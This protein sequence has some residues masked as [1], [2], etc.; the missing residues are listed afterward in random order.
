MNIPLDKQEAFFNWQIKEHQDEFSRYLNSSMKVLFERKEAFI[1]RVW[2]LDAARGNI[3]LRFK[4]GNC[5]RLKYPLQIITYSSTLDNTNPYDW[6]FS[7]TQF[8]ESYSINVSDISPI[9]YLKSTVDDGW[10]YIGCNGLTLDFIDKIS[11]SLSEGIKL[12]VVLAEQDPPIK[13]LLN[14]CNFVSNAKDNKTLN[15]MI[16]NEIENWRPRKVE[17]DQDQIALVRNELEKEDKLLVQGPPGTGKTYLIGEITAQ[18]LKEGKSVCITSLT[19][20]ALMEVAEKPGL[21]DALAQGKVYKT[22]LTTDEA[23]LVPRMQKADSLRITKGELLLATYYK[24][25]DWYA[26]NQQES[27]P[28]KPVYDVI[29]IEEASQAFL[30]TIA[31]F[32]K[33]GTKVL[34][35]GDPLQLQPIVLN[36]EG[37]KSIHSK[38][39]SYARGLATYAANSEVPAFRL[40]A[41]RRLTGKGALLTGV[42]YDD[43]LVSLQNEKPAIEALGSI[44]TFIPDEGGTL[45][46]TLS[47]VSGGDQPANAFEL[48]QEI[49]N[50][51]VETNP[52]IRIAVLSPF[53][54]TVKVL[55]DIL[56]SS[57]DDF[58]NLTVETIDRI[59]GL[60][61]DYTILVIPMT[62]PSFAFAINRFNVATSRSRTT[63]LIIADP[64]IKYLASVHPK[65]KTYLNKSTTIS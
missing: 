54:K 51:L 8:R 59:Q 58:S 46:K 49:V 17:V 57:F 7:Y 2:G 10:R 50:S 34:I 37:G 38:I 33:L 47:M 25:S 44:A 12:G 28:V 53:K 3:I 64:G 4:K 5:P 35:V 1:A 20:K 40:V 42:F 55:Q 11:K 29:I 19:N 22:N 39:I 45:I 23:K 13:Y 32:E 60:T 63:T 62:N 43:E 41:T 26:E 52:D 24:L 15:L 27:F 48:V 36:E 18:F 6:D 21:S 65:V 30:A 14:L 31:A 61:V 56:E 9:F 16:E